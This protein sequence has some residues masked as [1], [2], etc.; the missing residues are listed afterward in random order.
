M[1]RPCARR[2]IAS[3][4]GMEKGP[5]DGMKQ[6]NISSFQIAFWWLDELPE[7]YFYMNKNNDMTG[8]TTS[9]KK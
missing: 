4:F 2:A 1:L 9:A 6:K 5:E 8:R 7:C 3:S